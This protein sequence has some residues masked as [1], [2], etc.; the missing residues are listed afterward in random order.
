MLIKCVRLSQ[1]KLYDTDT[2]S[3]N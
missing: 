2:N 3:S 1:L